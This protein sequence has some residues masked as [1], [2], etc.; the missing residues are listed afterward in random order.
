[1]LERIHKD[2]GRVLLA[3][4]IH[5]L[6]WTLF[7]WAVVV[8]WLGTVV[9]MSLLGQRLSRLSEGLASG[10]ACVMVM[11]RYLL[12]PRI[13]FYEN[14][15]EIPPTRDNDRSSYLRWDQIERS[16]WDGDRLVLTGTNS[17]LAGGPV[18]GGSVRIPSAQHLAV[19]QILGR[20]SAA[21]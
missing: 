18:Q 4:R 8:A 19:E 17:V 7:L 20:S 5:S 14:G 3:I 9:V 11:L 15:V 2:R 12:Y 21:G 13:K 10:S 6:G 1:M 16:S